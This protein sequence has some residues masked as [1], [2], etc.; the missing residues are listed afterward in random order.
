M[1]NFIS[2]ASNSRKLFYVMLAG[3]ILAAPVM[4]F[5]APT[6]D[7]VMKGVINI[8]FEVAKYV[9]IVLAVSGIFQLILA[10]KDDNADGQS[11]AVR[12]VVVA[13]VLLGLKTLVQLTGLI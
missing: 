2:K 13:L 12:L 10:Y 11:R 3:I 5:C 1:N 4:T 9:G 8:I 7:Q 6:T